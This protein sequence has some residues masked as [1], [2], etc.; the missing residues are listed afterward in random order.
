MITSQIAID[1]NQSHPLGKHAGAPCCQKVLEFLRQHPRT[2]F[3]GLAM[4]YALRCH[5]LYTEKALSCFTDNGLIR[6]Y[7]KNNIPFYSLIS[8]EL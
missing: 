1:D 2:Q 8:K 6:R 5:R 4:V 7:L 3:S